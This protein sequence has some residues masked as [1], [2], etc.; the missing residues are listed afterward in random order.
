M[1]AVV[2]AGGEGSRLRPLTL[3]RPKPMLPLVHRVVMAHI[4]ELLVRNQITDVIATL[5]YRAEDIQNYFGDGQGLGLNL[6][7]SVEAHPLGTA[8]SVKFAANQFDPCKPFLVLSGDALTD[9]NLAEIVAFH[10]SVGALATLT[11]KRVPNPLDYGVVA[12]ADTGRVGLN[13]LKDFGREDID[14]RVDCVRNDLAPR[15][16]FDETLN[17]AR[18]SQDCDA[19]RCN[20]RKSKIINPKSSIR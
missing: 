8:G 16:F 6:Q 12:L 9:F 4:G 2:M 18:V 20:N 1:K 17:A 15:R 7:Y 5:R 19:P 14:A 11:L 10:E 13:L 3:N